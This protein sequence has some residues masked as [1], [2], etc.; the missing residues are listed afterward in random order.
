MLL[1]LPEVQRIAADVA[2]STNPELEVVAAITSVAG[3]AYTEVT[4]TIH[5]CRQEPCVLVI[6]A[7][8]NASESKFRSEVA[9]KL[10]QHLDRHRNH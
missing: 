4:V 10:R 3:S 5:G 6:G 2:H 9:E 1:S 7:E 8:R